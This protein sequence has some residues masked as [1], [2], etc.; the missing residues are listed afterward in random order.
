VPHIR[1]S[2][3]D[4]GLDFQVKVL[5]TC[6]LLP[7]RS[8]ATPKDWSSEAAVRRGHPARH[9]RVQQRSHGAPPL[10]AD[11]LLYRNV[12]R[13]RGGLVFQAHRPFRRG[14]PERHRRLQQRP[15]GANV[16][17]IRQSR[18]DS[19]LDLQ[20]KVLKIFKF[21]PFRSEAAPKDWSPEASLRRGHP[22]GHR[23]LQQRP[24][25]VEAVGA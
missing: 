25:G 2:K 13:F 22:E 9:R 15:H 16:P 17:H 23:R 6:K 14:H 10:E 3:S 11:Q 20:V 19:G 12:Q 21:L 1:Q 18:S 4:S 7:F 8:E 5:K 24:H